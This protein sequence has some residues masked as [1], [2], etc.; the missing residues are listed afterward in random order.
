MDTLLE[1]EIAG[2]EVPCL[3]LPIAN[4]Q[5]L[6]PTFTIAEMI[7][8]RSPLQKVGQEKPKWFLG[9]LPWRGLTIPMLSFEVITGH[10]SPKIDNGSQIAIFNNPDINAKLPF[11]AIPT[12]GIPHLSRITPEGILE[13]TNDDLKPYETMRVDIAGD[14]AIIPNIS[15]LLDACIELMGL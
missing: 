7:H 5:L 15:A 1:H 13:L 9:D 8:Y 11:F 12:T 14:Q 4:G 3:L 10:N 6:L 2:D